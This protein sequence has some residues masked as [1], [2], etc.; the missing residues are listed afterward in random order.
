MKTQTIIAITI[1]ILALMI[2]STEAIAAIDGP[3][4]M[5][6]VQGRFAGAAAGWEDT[7]KPRAE[8]LFWV[9][10]IISMIWTHGFLILKKADIGE[11]YVEF[12][13]F[14]IT[15]GFF[16]WLLTN[17][18]AMAT[19]IFASMQT[20][21][22]TA[23]GLAQVTPS[24]ILDVGFQVFGRAISATSAWHPITALGLV[25]M[26]LIVLAIF[27]VVATNMLVLYVSGWMLAYAGIIYLG[28]GGG[29]WTSDMAITY[30]K[31]VLSIAVQLMGM[32][33]IVGIGQTFVNEYMAD[34]DAGMTFADM[35]SF[36]VAAIV[37]LIL[38][39]KVPPM[40]GQLAMGGGAGAIGNGLGGSAVMAA[41]AA[42]GAALGLAG[43]M[44]ASGATNAAG[45]I[46]ALMAAADKAS[47][48]MGSGSDTASGMS[49]GSSDSQQGGGD[50]PSGGGGNS[51]SPLASA[52]GDTS[53]G[54]STGGP[55][56]GKS[57]AKNLATGIGQV[58]KEKFM[59]RTSKTLGGQVAAAIKNGGQSTPTFDGN[60]LSGTGDTPNL[61]EEVAAFTNGDSNNAQSA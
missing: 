27:A 37:L 20:L 47:E 53:G 24:G 55:S 8:W 12:I 36:I 29:R 2:P 1:S 57:I 41:A 28:F 60:S 58:A 11:F 42:A 16:W 15:T 4:I 9:L 59:D 32:V 35:G 25:G 30:Y 54:G 22:S 40:L 33:L 38:V 43:G 10:A 3:G 13:R 26:G 19:G 56:Y 46:Q 45:G 39:N 48:S 17:G 23:A 6:D 61:D 49:G 21:G 51:S 50:Q 18:P 34:M 7:F 5:D 31:T 44:I 14:T 52:M